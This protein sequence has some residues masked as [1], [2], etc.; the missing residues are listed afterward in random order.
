[1]ALLFPGW[2]ISCSNT[3]SLLRSLHKLPTIPWT[4]TGNCHARHWSTW[5]T[6]FEVACVLCV[7]FGGVG[8]QA[9]FCP[10]ICCLASSWIQSC[11]FPNLFWELNIQESCLGFFSIAYL[12]RPLS[13]GLLSFANCMFKDMDLLSY[14]SSYIHKTSFGAVVEAHYLVNVIQFQLKNK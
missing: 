5:P 6:A 1:M 8:P 7:F 14:S 9:P 13:S 11:S 12:Y 10:I 2:H 3:P 4:K